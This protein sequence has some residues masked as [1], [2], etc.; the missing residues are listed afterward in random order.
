[1][2]SAASGLGRRITKED[3]FESSDDFSIVAV[4]GSGSV[5]SV[6]DLD[7]DANISRGTLVVASLM[8]FLIG[9]SYSIV[10]PTA[11]QYAESLDAPESFEGYVVG[12]TPLGAALL[13][14]LYRLMLKKS[15]AGCM[16]FQIA[17]MQFGS[18]LYSLAQVANKVELLI[19]GRLLVGFGGSYYPVYQFIAEMVGKKHR[20]HVMGVCGVGRALGFCLGPV[21][22]AILVYVD[23]HIGD[24]TINKETNAGWTV[25][26]YCAFQTAMVVWYFPREGSKLV[27]RKRRQD[28]GGG[29]EADQSNGKPL[30]EKVLHNLMLGFVIMNGAL[31][32]FFITSWEISATNIIQTR[33]NWSIQYSALLV[34]GIALTPAISAPLIGKL[35]YRIHDKHILLGC[36]STQLVSAVTL[37]DFGSPVLFLIGSVFYFQA[38]TLQLIFSFAT[39]S[40]VC[41][42]HEIEPMQTW[43]N[44]I[45]LL[46]RGAGAI[47]GANLSTNGLGMCCVAGAVLSLVGIL[48]FYRRLVYKID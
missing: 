14:P 44:T 22:A 5:R 39:S 4:Q 12:V 18:V 15:Y 19:A 48:V 45:A 1:M 47:G 35:S 43:I 16:H 24:L 36:A 46:L 13:M 42:Q 29:E 40:K 25:A 10:I 6:H 33:F 32:S 11:R 8:L 20:S 23:F 41:Y 34:G 31:P 17:C 7:E 37:F 26:I 30:K 3:D 21:V 2:A 9:F 38:V 27:G 28:L